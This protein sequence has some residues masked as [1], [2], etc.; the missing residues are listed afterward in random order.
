MELIHGGDWVG[1][2]MEIGTLPL[3]FSANISPLGMPERV[4]KAAAEA[5]R[6]AERY[7]DPLNRELRTALAAYHGVEKETIVCGNGAS[8][9]IDRICRTL[10]PRKGAVFCPGFAEYE[11]ALREADCEIN[12]IPL[13][14]ETDFLPKENLMAEIP[15]DCE[16]VFLCNPNNP[17]GRLWSSEM[18]AEVLGCCR[19]TG[20]VLVVDEC[21][22]DFCESADTGSLVRE[23][24]RESNLL[25]LKAFTKTW[26]MAG[27]RLGYVLC[28]SAKLAAA[29]SGC[30]QPWAVSGIAQAAGV[31]ALQE[32]DY[33][34]RLQYLITSQ[35]PRLED[36][37][38]ALGFRVIPG[39]ANFIL[40]HS[41]DPALT[42]KLRRRG[43]LIRSCSNF[44][45]LG[46][47]WYRCAVRTAEENDR[48]L[49]TL[50]EM[51]ED[52]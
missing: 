7:P 45:G 19:E 10:R 5:L 46:Q 18:L 24:E 29:I 34:K 8:N 48:L 23:L 3:D 40:F 26:A 12:C 30:G 41:E 36:G 44:S 13:P 32:Q 1:A 35:R 33:V 15:Q 43:I 27:L 37:L 16:I 4:R 21:F 31:A 20:A 2:L 39:E 17:T 6:S 49:N 28:G 47:G 51:R 52:G 25:I 11:R 50:W 9:L 38:R 22:L 42:E 14:E